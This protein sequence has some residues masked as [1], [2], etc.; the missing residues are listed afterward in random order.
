MECCGCFMTKAQS[1]TLRPKS[2][3][4]RVKSDKT[5]RPKKDQEKRSRP[6]EKMPSFNLNNNQTDL[7]IEQQNRNNQV[8][9]RVNIDNEVTRQEPIQS[10]SQKLGVSEAMRKTHVTMLSLQ[11]NMFYSRED[12]QLHSQI[13]NQDKDIKVN[14]SENKLDQLFMQPNIYQGLDGR[15]PLSDEQDSQ[16]ASPQSSALNQSPLIYAIKS[17]KYYCQF[18]SKSFQKLLITDFKPNID[19]S[20]RLI[21]INELF[22]SSESRLTLNQNTLDHQCQCPLCNQ[23]VYLILNASLYVGS[24]E[25]MECFDIV[26]SGEN[27]NL[28]ESEYDCASSSK[29]KQQH[30]SFI[31]KRSHKNLTLSAQLSEFMEKQ[32]MDRIILKNDLDSQSQISNRLTQVS[33]KTQHLMFK[34]KFQ[35]L[36]GSNKY[37]QMIIVGELPLSAAKKLQQSR[38]LSS[39]VMMNMT[40]QEQ[41]TI[42][43]NPDGQ[44][45]SLKS[46][47][48]SRNKHREVDGISRLP[49][50]F[51][52]HL[53]LKEYQK[54]PGYQKYTPPDLIHQVDKMQCIQINKDVMKAMLD[55]KMAK[56]KSFL[57]LKFIPLDHGNSKVRFKASRNVDFV[58]LG[59]SGPVKQTKQLA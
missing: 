15:C 58:G 36:K 31:N 43:Q 48:D 7:Q 46:Q 16:V 4:P 39:S 53:N 40:S 8:D 45:Q 34:H 44:R 32:S 5:K 54:T 12:S 55:N 51:K 24:Q 6:L 27:L 3:N 21:G 22:N 42:Q 35:K 20:V 14:K 2:Q 26:N 17:F 57:E 13:T 9:S 28:M 10:E 19:Q 56:N 47:Q 1:S 41:A 25:L 23:N 11:N 18:C 59:D 49:H 30:P 37:A 33:L 29:L 50:V 52:T 38:V